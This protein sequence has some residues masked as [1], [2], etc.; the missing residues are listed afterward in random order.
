MTLGMVGLWEILGASVLIA[1]FC[2]NQGAIK[3][4]DKSDWVSA[5]NE[6]LRG[7]NRYMNELLKRSQGWLGKDSGYA[8]L[9]G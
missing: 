9:Q 7:V 4:V 3:S 8:Q 2:E 5:E 6:I 1:E